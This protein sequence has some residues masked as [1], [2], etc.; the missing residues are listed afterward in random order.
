VLRSAGSHRGRSHGRDGGTGQADSP[1]HRPAQIRCLPL[2]PASDDDCAAA[3]ALAA[4]ERIGARPSVHIVI[5]RP[6]SIPLMLI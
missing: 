1:P 5:A 3:A 2:G 6:S 4:T